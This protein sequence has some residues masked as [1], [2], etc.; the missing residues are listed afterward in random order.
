[1]AWLHERFAQGDFELAYEKSDRQAADVMT[2]AF[3][4]ANKWAS[5]CQLVNHIWPKD[6][7][8]RL[9]APGVEQTVKTAA[10]KA[11]G[12]P[13]EPM[14]I[15]Q[16]VSLSEQHVQRM[17]A[18]LAKIDWPKQSR[19][20]VR[21]QGT[22]V[23]A[24]FDPK[25]PRLGTYTEKSKS[26]IR[27]INECIRSMPEFDSFVW[28]SLQ[29]N[30]DSVSAPHVDKNNT[31]PSVI[32]LLGTFTGGAFKMTDGGRASWAGLV[33]PPL[34]MEQD[35]TFPNRSKEQDTRLLRSCTIPRMNF[36]TR[37]GAGL[38]SSDFDFRERVVLVLTAITLLAMIGVSSNT[39]AVRTACSVAPDQDVKG[40]GVFV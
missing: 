19:A 15:G 29:I 24:T 8:A 38:K 6:L 31:G 17:E 1:V 26:D 18:A 40:A 2:K 13:A 27:V 21:G 35:N 37:T 39:V 30:K 25:G 3:A 20:V 9:E 34:S 36:R 28:G 16:V 33:K 12:A 14:V 4:D 7:S 22:C 5:V 23:G 11:L 10:L 32:I